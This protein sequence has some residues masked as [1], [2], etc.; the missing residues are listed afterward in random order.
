MIKLMYIT[1]NPTIAEIADSA[2]VDRVFIDL[3]VVGKAE[4][5][6]GMDTVQSHHSISDIPIVKQKLRN[7]EL[8]VRSNPIYNDSK[9]EINKIVTSGA[10]II[11]LP[12]FKTAEEVTHFVDYVG[13]RARTMLLFETKESVDCIDE[14]LAIDGIDEYYIGLNDLHLSY[15]LDFMFQLL[16][17]G[18]VD[19]IVT[20]FKATGKPYGFGGIAK[21]G[22]GLLPAEHVIAEH[23]RLGSTIGILSRSFCNCD[24][25][26]DKN[27][28]LSLFDDGVSEIRTLEYNLA[29]QSGEFFE[30]NHKFVINA[31]NDIVRIIRTK[32]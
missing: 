25:V 19:N 15:G 28:I 18:T 13:G 21:L 7:S 11:M 20:K 10:D 24:K 23:Y 1:N 22:G 17:D 3:E 5:Q 26:S 2:G 4:R 30:E 27:I 6:G 16:A 31:V 8:L 9:N 14:I 12:F 32:K 29:N